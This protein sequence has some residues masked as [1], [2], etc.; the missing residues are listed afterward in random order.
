MLAAYSFGRFC[1]SFLKDEV[2]VLGPLH[3]SHIISLALFVFS[4]ALLAY[5]KARLVKP[6]RA[7]ARDEVIP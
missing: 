2:S 4:I 6:E 3:Q 1:L 7:V 5:R